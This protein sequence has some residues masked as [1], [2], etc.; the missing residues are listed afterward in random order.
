MTFASLETTKQVT[1]S[2]RIYN[3]GRVSTISADVTAQT[4]STEFTSAT[5][6]STLSP[7]I[8]AWL[9]QNFIDALLPFQRWPRF[10]LRPHSSELDWAFSPKDHGANFLFLSGAQEQ[11][12]GTHGSAVAA[13]Q[14]QVQGP[15]KVSSMSA[16]GNLQVRGLKADNLNSHRPV[17][18][19]SVAEASWLSGFTFLRWELKELLRRV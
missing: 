7:S 3:N 4:S 15:S 12:S 8:I 11:H 9:P 6:S 19:Y 16:R 2:C 18:L 17:R 13:N 10:E 5:R 1:S 14:G